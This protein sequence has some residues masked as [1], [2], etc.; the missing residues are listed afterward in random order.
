MF[1]FNASGSS[2]NSQG[3]SSQDSSA[4]SR[5]VPSV[6]IAKQL[7]LEEEARRTRNGDSSRVSHPWSPQNG[8]TSQEYWPGPDQV[9]APGYSS[10]PLGYDTQPQPLPSH[11]IFTSALSSTEPAQHQRSTPIIGA[12]VGQPGLSTLSSKQHSD[13]SEAK[14][15]SNSRSATSSEFP[16]SVPKGITRNGRPE[17]SKD[18]I[19]T[20]NGPVRMSAIAPELNTPRPST[21][22]I[23]N[24]GG[25]SSVY[26]SSGHLSNSGS[27]MSNLQSAL[28]DAKVD[29]LTHK[30]AAG[31]S[32]LNGSLGPALGSVS[33]I[34]QPA[35]TLASPK[36]QSDVTGSK[37]ANGIPTSS[38]TA[39]GSSFFL[40]LDSTG[41]RQP[42]KPISQIAKGYVGEDDKDNERYMPSIL[43]STASGSKVRIVLVGGHLGYGESPT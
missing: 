34:S 5:Y 6:Y 1:T 36:L 4:K 23:F 38:A 33:G 25:G 24:Q 22:S 18:D 30:A 8:S 31:S 42:G 16:S 26:F 12:G 21:P 15:S 29:V 27:G 3:R 28:K 17:L 37:R 35:Q 20:R 19:N 11:S 14:S 10:G 39:I 32:S 43:L 7:A 41:M 9:L 13:L 40:S 2:T